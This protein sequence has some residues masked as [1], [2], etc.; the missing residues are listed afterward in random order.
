MVVSQGDLLARARE[1]LSTPFWRHLVPLALAAATV[2]FWLSEFVPLAIRQ[3]RNH[4][5][6]DYD[7][8]I[9]D[10]TAWLL[11]RGQGFITLRGRPFLGHHLN[12][13][14]ALFAP[15]YRLGAGPELLN[16]AALVALA[17]CVVPIAAIA[18]RYRPATSWYAPAFAA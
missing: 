2:M 17:A 7:L 6:F 3:Q 13:G 10:Q 18:H 1:E 11:S 9:F 12:W 5:T 4:A 8:G 14:L 16:I 15:A